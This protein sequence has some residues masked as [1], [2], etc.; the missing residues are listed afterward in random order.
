MCRSQSIVQAA[1]NLGALA[2]SIVIG[3]VG[4]WIAAALPDPIGSGARL[5]NEWV[6]GLPGRYFAAGLCAAISIALGIRAFRISAPPGDKPKPFGG[7]S[8]LQQ[9]PR[10]A[11]QGWPATPTSIYKPHRAATPEE[12]AEF[13]SS[14]AWVN[15]DGSY[16][17]HWVPDNP[18]AVGLGFDTTG[19]YALMTSPDGTKQVKVQPLDSVRR[20][21]FAKIPP[22][23]R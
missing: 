21:A 3:A 22:R 2:G 19:P 15:A 14:V 6:L 9:P 10:W 18:G 13:F 4:S 17:G 12:R 7:S 5:F 11:F 1:K 23:K 8:T 20:A 16:G